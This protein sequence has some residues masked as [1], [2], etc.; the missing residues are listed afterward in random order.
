MT[1]KKIGSGWISGS[2]AIFFGVLAL[3]G[4]VTFM[5]PSILTSPD[6]RA[7]Y[8]L[9]LFRFLIGACLYLSFVFGVL[10]IILRKWKWLGVIGL[11]CALAAQLL[12][13]AKV[14][15]GKILG[16]SF[17]FL[18]GLFFFCFFFLSFF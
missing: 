14:E 4:V 5:Y 7:H 10:C 15:A 9:D 12:G 11:T 18:L 3:G 8:P 2:V 1:D 13:G 16:I 17:Y 6:F